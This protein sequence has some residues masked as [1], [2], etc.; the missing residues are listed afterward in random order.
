MGD[1]ENLE[2]FYLPT[3]LLAKISRPIYNTHDLV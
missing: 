2:S 3:V 1:L